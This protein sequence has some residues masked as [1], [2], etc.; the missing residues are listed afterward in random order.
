MQGMAQDLISEQGQGNT[1][2]NSPWQGGFAYGQLLQAL[3]NLTGSGA[4]A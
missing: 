4:L 1:C 3:E 2:W